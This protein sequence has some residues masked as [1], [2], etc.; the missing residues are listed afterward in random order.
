MTI[1]V[2][3][4]EDKYG[5]EEI[6]LPIPLPFKLTRRRFLMTLSLGLGGLAAT[7]A[8]AP[9]IGFIFTPFIRRKQEVWRP[10]GAVDSFE[11]GKTQYVTFVNASPLPWAGVTSKTGSWVQRTGDQEFIAYSINC[12]HLGCPVRWLEG[13]QLFMCPCHGGVYYAT[14]E[15]AAGPP[16][17]PLPKY[18][19]RV[20]NGQVEIRTSPI[21]WA[22]K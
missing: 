11:I 7:V 17:A 8:S 20:Q 13:A 4:P 9:I 10:V 14:G 19:V 22:G 6:K 16:P 3:L 18:P 1:D 5:Q 12:T 21:P 2:E 15:V